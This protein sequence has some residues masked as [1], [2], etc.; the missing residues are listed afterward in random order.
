MQRVVG[1]NPPVGQ[2]VTKTSSVSP[3]ANF[4]STLMCQ[5]YWQNGKTVQILIGDEAACL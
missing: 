3:K 1:S 5:K 4:I 2:P